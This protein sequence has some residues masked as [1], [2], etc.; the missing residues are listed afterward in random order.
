MENRYSNMYEMFN[1]EQKAKSYFDSLPDYVRDR[2][3]KTTCTR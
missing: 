3:W 2:K 1:S